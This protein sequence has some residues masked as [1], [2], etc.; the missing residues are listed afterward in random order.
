MSLAI[1]AINAYSAVSA[2][3]PMN[4]AVKNQSDVS[5][6]YME[7]INE[8]QSVEGFSGIGAVNP[9][10]YPNA[11]SVEINPMMKLA[12][13]QSVSKDLNAIASGFSGITTGYDSTSQS[14]GYQTIG[15]V[16]DLY[17]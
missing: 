15:S 8:T 6:A 3:R 12:K 1:N 2:V 7:S 10:Q 13:T 5:S 11:Q 4:Y 9:T 14:Y 17:A 16:I